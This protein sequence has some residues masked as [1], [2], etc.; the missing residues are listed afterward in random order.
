MPARFQWFGATQAV[1]QWILIGIALLVLGAAMWATV[2]LPTGRAVYATGSDVEAA[3][4]AGL[5][6]Q[7]ITFGVFVLLGALTG[8]A[9]ALEAV[10]KDQL[11][12]KVGDQL[13]MRAIAAAVVGGIAISGGR[14]RIIGCL[15]GVALLQTI[16][17]ALN[18][19]GLKAEWEKA[20]QGLIIL[21][22]VAS[23]ALHRKRG[24]T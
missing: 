5:R 4:L 9:A 19:L 20:F 8:L 6:P 23:D 3:R 11:G 14:G 13:E 15:L 10:R 18:Y 7:R 16:A 22:S 17:P 21:V 12:P 24:T 1:G 2:F